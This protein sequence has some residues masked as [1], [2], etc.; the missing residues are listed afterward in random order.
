MKRKYLKPTSVVIEL[1]T[2]LL[3]ATSSTTGNA[4]DFEGDSDWDN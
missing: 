3:I 2:Q 4:R 1:E